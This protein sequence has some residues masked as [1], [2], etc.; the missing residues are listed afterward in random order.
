MVKTQIS[1]SI[2]ISRKLSLFYTD[3]V[4]V[5]VFVALPITL[6]W[7]R[8]YVLKFLCWQRRCRNWN[9]WIH[10]CEMSIVHCSWHLHRLKKNYV[11][12]RFVSHLIVAQKSTIRLQFTQ[13]VIVILGWK[14]ATSGTFNQIQG[15]GCRETERRERELLE[16]SYKSQNHTMIP[17]FRWMGILFCTTIKEQ[18]I[19][20][21]Y[22]CRFDRTYFA[23]SLSLSTT[24][25]LSLWSASL[26]Q[27]MLYLSICLSFSLSLWVDIGTILTHLVV[28]FFGNAQN[29]QH[30]KRTFLSKCSL[31]VC[32]WY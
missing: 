21:E 14:P 8:V 25:L 18:T 6:R 32:P 31:I 30:Q 5:V 19:E 22:W 26:W 24:V 29:Q 28:N 7:I 16:V 27:A 13:K 12:F 17:Y 4:V 3:F 9:R 23:C 11:K 2:L 20:T 10:A 1:V 15:Q